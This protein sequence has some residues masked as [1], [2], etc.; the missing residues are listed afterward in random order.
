MEE[1]D[2]LPII[3]DIIVGMLF[4]SNIIKFVPKLFG[5]FSYPFFFITENDDYED[6]TGDDP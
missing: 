2:F 6:T 4:P 5:R 1:C 3:F